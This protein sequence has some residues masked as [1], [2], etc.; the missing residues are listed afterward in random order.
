[1]HGK[2][3][4]NYGDIESQTNKDFM[5]KGK[6]FRITTLKTLSCTFTKKTD[7]EYEVLVKAEGYW[8][9]T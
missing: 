2:L 6:R 7:H 9:S 1:L 8:S 3:R 4:K 5:A